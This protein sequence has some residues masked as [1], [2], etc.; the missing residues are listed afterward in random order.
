M[1]LFMVAYSWQWGR[2]YG[3]SWLTC[4]LCWHILMPW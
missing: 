2:H 3:K 4:L 1:L